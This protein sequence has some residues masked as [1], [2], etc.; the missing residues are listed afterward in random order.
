VLNADARIL[1][2]SGL[3]VVERF[4]LD[5]TGTRLMRSYVAEDPEYFADSWKGTDVVAPADVAY[6][7]YSC[8]DPGGAPAGR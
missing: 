1:H 7:P 5:A 4:E 8:R 6:A 2:G 3:R